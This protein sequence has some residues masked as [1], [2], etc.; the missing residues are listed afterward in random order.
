MSDVYPPI[1]AAINTGIIQPVQDYTNLLPHDC[2]TGNCT[3]PTDGEVSFSTLGV[4]HFCE[5]IT[6]QVQEKF[7][8]TNRKGTDPLTF[9]AYLNTSTNGNVSMGIGTS[10]IV[11]STGSVKSTLRTLVTV[12]MLHKPSF[13]VLKA[14]AISCSICP[15]VLTYG[16]N[17]TKSIMCEKQIGV[18]RIGDN[19]LAGRNGPEQFVRFKLAKSE[20]FRNGTI[21]PCDRQHKADSGFTPVSHGNIGAAPS[22]SSWNSSATDAELWYYPDDCVYSMSKGA[23]DGIESYFGEIFDGQQLG[24]AGSNG[25][26]G[27]IYLRQFHQAGNMTLA[28]V[29][30]MFRKITAAMTATIRTHGRNSDAT[31]ATGVVWCQT[32]CMKIRWKW[33]S[34]PVA[35][36]GLSLAFLALVA[37]ESRDVAK[38]RLWKSSVLA[39]SFCDMDEVHLC[40]MSPTKNETIDVI[41]RSTSKL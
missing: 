8:N 28:T 35:L 26:G 23:V 34:Y 18:T 17:I 2:T 14:L 9:L 4:G 13:H 40:G 36:I 1:I 24:N 31:Q 5:E 3:F 16:V 30:D 41:V 11:L 10:V 21:V 12:K 25:I 38:D 33:L 19:L 37:I 20:T 15:V 6:S 27:S 29:D 22:N 32:T 39:M 7:V